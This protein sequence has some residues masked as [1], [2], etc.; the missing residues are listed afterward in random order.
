MGRKQDELKAED[1][2]RLVNRLPCE[3]LGHMGHVSQIWFKIR[4]RVQSGQD[5]FRLFPKSPDYK[6]VPYVI[7]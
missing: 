4:D 1:L 7:H 3:H 5:Q 6:Y 2:R